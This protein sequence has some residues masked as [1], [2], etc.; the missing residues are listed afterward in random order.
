MSFLTFVADLSQKEQFGA[1][2]S[3]SQRICQCDNFSKKT[4]VPVSATARL[5]LLVCATRPPRRTRPSMASVRWSPTI[6]PPMV[7]R[8]TS[9][10]KEAECSP[11]PENIWFSPA[12]SGVAST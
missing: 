7:S 2:I 5:I 4:P 12:Q 6:T 8:I 11:L 10:Y 1:V 9:G 3:V